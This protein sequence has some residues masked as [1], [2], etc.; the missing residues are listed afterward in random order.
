MSN[1]GEPHG[2]TVR[3]LLGH[4]LVEG[5]LLNMYSKCIFAAV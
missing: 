3:C 5:L 4:L 1:S 2:T